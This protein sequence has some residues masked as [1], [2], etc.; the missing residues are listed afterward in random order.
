MATYVG[1]LCV[2]WG[3][4]ALAELGAHPWCTSET[5][6]TRDLMLR[7]VWEW[8]EDVALSRDFVGTRDATWLHAVMG[9]AWA[10]VGYMHV[11]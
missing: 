5:R 10:I 3:V 9:M 1:D 4:H 7:A 6:H 2:R 8:P 11:W